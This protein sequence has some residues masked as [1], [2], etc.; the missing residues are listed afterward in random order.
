MKRRWLLVGLVIVMFGLTLTVYGDS[1]SPR[2]GNNA[3]NFAL[4]DLEGKTVGLRTVTGTHKVTLVNFWATWC[5]PCRKEIP[6][7]NA[8]YNDYKNKSVE[9][10]AVNLQEDGDALLAFVQSNKMKFPVLMDQDGKVGERYRVY[11]IPTTFVLD[12]KGKIREIIQG[13]ASYTRL[14]NAIENVLKEG[15]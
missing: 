14:K 2:I 1:S 10:L 5:P 7:L 4:K 9:I 13:G 11:Y 8:I 12:Q 3:P 6:D 15:A